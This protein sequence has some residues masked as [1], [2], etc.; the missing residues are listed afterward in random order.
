MFA[1]G[2]APHRFVKRFAVGDAPHRF[3]KRFAASCSAQLRTSRL[4]RLEGGQGT[5]CEWAAHW[6]SA[7]RAH[8]R[9]SDSDSQAGGARDERRTSDGSIWLR[10]PDSNECLREAI[11]A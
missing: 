9:S 10:G 1:V 5:Q 4:P 7:R 6:E 2:D 3:V 8:A 11:P